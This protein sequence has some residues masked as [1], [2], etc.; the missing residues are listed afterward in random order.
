MKPEETH[1]VQKRLYSHRRS[2]RGEKN[3][4]EGENTMKPRT[5]SYALKGEICAKVGEKQ[6]TLKHPHLAVGEKRGGE[7]N[8]KRL[9]LT[10]GTNQ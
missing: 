6:K 10:L 9:T 7:M 5:A 2:T 3:A 1:H 8:N 4:K